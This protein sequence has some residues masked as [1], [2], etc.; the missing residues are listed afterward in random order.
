MNKDRIDPV[1]E[2]ARESF[3]ASDPPSWAGGRPSSTPIE[4]WSDDE[5]LEQ[6]RY[7][8]TQLADEGA[9][10]DD[11]DNEPKDVIL[12]EIRRRGLPVED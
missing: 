6:Y 1:D 8:K 2:A 3:P 9:G 10:N 12:E 5:L 7:V 11:E 4:E